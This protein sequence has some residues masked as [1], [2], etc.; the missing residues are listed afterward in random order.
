MSAHRLHTNPAPKATFAD[1]LESFLHVLVFFGVRFL[2]HRLNDAV[3]AS[4]E[5]K[6][7]HRGG[8]GNSCCPPAR[9]LYSS[10]GR[11]TNR[12]QIPWFYTDEGDAD[13]DSE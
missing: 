10:W 11:Y 6:Y 3:A 12:L 13:S 9:R 4:F 2:P 8:Y 5:R 1:D 7:F